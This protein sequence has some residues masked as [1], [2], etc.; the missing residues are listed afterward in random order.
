MRLARKLGLKSRKVRNH[1]I[2]WIYRNSRKKG[3]MMCG[4]ILTQKLRRMYPFVIPI[5]PGNNHDYLL[6]Y[7]ECHQL[8]HESPVKPSLVGSGGR[9]ASSK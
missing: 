9:I 1:K 7:A 3:A 2:K 6:A 5:R 8:E 4:L